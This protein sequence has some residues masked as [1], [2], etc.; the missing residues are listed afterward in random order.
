MYMEWIKNLKY[1]ES[2]IILR[3]T[4]TGTDQIAQRH[5]DRKTERHRGDWETQRLRDTEN[6]RH[7]D[8]ET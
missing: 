1:I 2:E 4:G 6:E 5:R 7:R 8:W 3:I